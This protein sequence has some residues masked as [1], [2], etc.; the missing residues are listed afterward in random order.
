MKK[1]LVLAGGIPQIELIRHLKARGYET[2]LADYTP[3]PVAEPFADRF[4]QVSTLDIDGIRNIAVNEKVDLLLTVCTDQALNTVATVSEELGLP[5]Y[6][7]AETGRNVTNKKYM[8]N[9]FARHEIPTAK[10]VILEENDFSVP[11]DIPY[12][13]IVKPVDCNSSKGVAKVTNKEELTAALSAA[14]RYSRTHNAIVEEF[15]EGKEL[16][17]D[18]LVKDGEPEILCVSESDKAKIDGKFIIYRSVVPAGVKNETYGKIHEIAK[19]IAQA[20]ALKDCPML[21][22]MLYRD[23]E[24]YVIEFSARTG[25]GLKY[26]LIE[27]NSGV[28]IIDYA[29]DAALG[30]CRSVKPKFTG[31]YI[32]NEFIYTSGGV[33]DHVEGFDEAVADGSMQSY[34]VFHS[35]GTEFDSEIRSSGDRIAGFTIVADTYEEYLEKNSRI[36]SSVKVIDDHGKDMM[37]HDISEPAT[38]RVQPSIKAMEG[39]K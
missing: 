32:I 24:L 39:R 26:Q 33:F 37:R 20:F 3:H 10:F 18:V 35:K 1:A 28:D 5:C 6:I 16:S 23:G 36:A 2:I 31:K 7:A 4:Y 21:I 38:R 34:Y 9:V 12:P 25:G 22:Q 19:K 14:F 27:Q 15:V 29:I 8:K 13:I 17:V 11:E 30:T